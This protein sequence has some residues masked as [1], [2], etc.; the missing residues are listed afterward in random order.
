MR[1]A[2][3]RLGRPLRW[4]GSAL[5]LGG[6]V[7]AMVTRGWWTDIV[8]RSKTLRVEW[9]F[10]AVLL[11]AAAMG[12]GVTRWRALLGG[13]GIRL[14][15]PWLLRTY[16]VGRFVGAYTPSTVGLDVYRTMCVAEVVRERARPAM[17]IFVE[18]LL[19][20]LGLA[21][22]GLATLP[23]GASHFVSGSLPW[24]L[25][26]VVIV[27]SGLLAVA[28]RPAVLASLVSKLP[29]R[30]SSPALRVLEGVRLGGL[31][32][33]QLLGGVAISALGHG[34]MASVF[35]ATARA[36]GVDLSAGELILVGTAIILGTLLPIS[37]SGFGVREG[38]AIMLLGMRGVPQ[39]DA[40]L[41]GVLGYVTGQSI[42]LLG[43][44]LTLVPK[45]EPRRVAT[46]QVIYV[47]P[48]R[49][50]SVLRAESV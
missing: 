36:L 22:V 30:L 40:V 8:E 18:K 29:S 44:L 34:A 45:P 46:R 35:W 15:V 26:A 33:R 19:G 23:L 47:G 1:I 27:S 43:G 5:L 49:R 31:D 20:F 2:F 32:R 21:L 4:G 9:L 41:V 37:V 17:I 38:I 6:I 39:A 11:H 48:E 24:V 7:H 16:L 12:L 28:C 3:P 25:V 10:V 14:R 50:G 42:A 13:E